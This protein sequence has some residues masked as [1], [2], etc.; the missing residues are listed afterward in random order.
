MIVDRTSTHDANWRAL[1]AHWRVVVVDTETNGLFGNVRIL[2]LAAVELDVGF[3]VDS[4]AWLLNPGRVRL[5]TEAQPR[6]A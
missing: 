5:S 1:T 2:S 6:T 4:R 3:V